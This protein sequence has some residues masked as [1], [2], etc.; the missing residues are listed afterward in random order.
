MKQVLVAIV[1]CLAAGLG[2]HDVKAQARGAQPQPQRQP[3]PAQPQ[4]PLTV[5]QLIQAIDC[6][7]TSCLPTLTSLRDVEQMVERRGVSFQSDE[8]TIRILKEFGATD[9]IISLIPHVPPPAPP[10]FAGQ[11]TVLCEPR[12]CAVV[13]SDKYF[14][15]T[16]QGRKVVNG[17][18]PGEARI[19]IFSDGFEGE[20]R[21]VRLEEGKPSE[22]KFGL[23][24]NRSAR[25]QIGKE[26]LLDVVSALGGIN[27]MAYLADVE[28]AGMLQWTDTNGAK[29]QWAMNF[30]RRAGNQVAM[31]FKSR[32]GECSATVSGGAQAARKECKGKLKNVAEGVAEQAAVLFNSYQVPAVLQALLGRNL[33]ISPANKGRLETSGGSDSYVLTVG[34]EN[35]PTELVYAPP[36]GMPPVKV[37]YANYMNVDNLGRYPGRMTLGQVGKEPGWVF[38]LNNS[39]TRRAR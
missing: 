31:T 27:G 26:F 37:E 19:Q 32:D 18:P 10:K 23:Q 8:T 35:F 16:E 28:G 2:P 24:I 12:D 9:R 15:F 36:N 13:V 22:E 6:V 21:P 34:T 25:Q 30:T 39:P 11:L 20:T 4:A 38:T 29:Q 14:G 17:L 3:A 33:A 5:G 7:A 1:L